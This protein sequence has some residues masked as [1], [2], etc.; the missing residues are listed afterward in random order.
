MGWGP[1]FKTW[2]LF[3]LRGA[4]RRYANYIEI[5]KREGCAGLCDAEKR[6]G[7]A[8]EGSFTRPTSKEWTRTRPR[9][10][11]LRNKTAGRGLGGEGAAPPAQKQTRP[12][13]KE[14]V[15]HEHDRLDQ[16]DSIRFTCP[17][18]FLITDTLS[19]S[20]RQKTFVL[21][22]RNK[23]GFLYSFGFFKQRLYAAET[24][25]HTTP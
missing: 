19:C 13:R 20:L 9:T 14:V 21:P 6:D 23:L 4:G 3:L 7:G 12:I 16:I 5:E 25:W 2:P 15:E 17:C 8:G 1:C 10:G 24:F 22:P 18:F 11:N